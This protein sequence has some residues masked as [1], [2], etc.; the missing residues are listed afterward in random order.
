M[1]G[2]SPLDE[3]SSETRSRAIK[4]VTRACNSC[5]KRKTKCDG[6]KPQCSV[7]TIHKR[8]C[9]YSQQIDKR[10]MAAKGKISTLVAYVQDLESIL[11]QHHIDLPHS[12][13]RHFLPP[14]ITPSFAAGDPHL[15]MSPT[16]EDAIE[17]AEPTIEQAIQNMPK[18]SPIDTQDHFSL[19]GES[20]LDMTPLSDR[21]GSLQIAEDGQL[22]FFGPTSNLH[23]SHVGP[24]P[25]F[26]SNIR[27]IHWNESLI[28]T[29]AGV[30][31][32][33]EEELEAHLTKLYFAWENPNIP[34]VDERAYYRGKDC[35]RKLN[36]PNNRYS[37]VLNN[38]M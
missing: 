38:A 21:M 5:Q 2:A 20:S 15:E 36:Q 31:N 7:C 24:F 33:V 34:L 14:V 19:S 3:P 12:R 10:R 26:N 8:D 11:L 29:A 25:L 35:Y 16:A 28:L 23:I 18:D 37:E 22:R 4:H 1:V 30:N 17:S 27:S 9:T 6:L 13:P 32:H